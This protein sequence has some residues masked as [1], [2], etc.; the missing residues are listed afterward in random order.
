MSGKNS[1]CGWRD[2]E[3]EKL[4]SAMLAYPIQPLKLSMIVKIQLGTVSA[5]GSLLAVTRK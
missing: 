1:R 3:D 5:D 4:C 2:D